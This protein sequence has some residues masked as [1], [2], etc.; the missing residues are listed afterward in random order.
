MDIAQSITV[1]MPELT[2]AVLSMGLLLGGL[3]K[4]ADTFR[5]INLLALIALALTGMAIYWPARLELLTSGAQAAQTAFMDMFRED[6]FA[7]FAK[8]LILLASALAL[9]MSGKPLKN[10]R[11][12]RPEYYALV[13]LATLGMMLMV[14]ANHGLALYVGLELQSLTLYVLA[15]FRRDDAQSSEAGLKY[16][17]L[18][19]LSSGLL[20]YGLSL[21]YGFAGTLDFSQL[22]TSLGAKPATQSQGLVVG[23]VFICAALAFKI[24]AV[25]FHMWTPDVY[26]GAP[27]PVTTLLAAAPKIA[28]MALLTRLLYGPFGAMSGQWQQILIFAA[29]ASMLVGASAGVIQSSLK[30]LMAYS[31]IANIGFA[32]IGLATAGREGAEASFVYLSIYAVNALGAFGVLLALR[33]DGKAL[34]DLKDVAGLARTNPALAF[35]MAVFMFSLAGVPPLA[36]F[37][38]KYV[39]FV[40]AV[41]AHMVPL[42]VLGVVASAIA[43]FYYLRIVKLMYFDEAQGVSRSAAAAD[44]V[45]NSS[46]QDLGLRAVIG[47]TAL[48]ALAF[49]LRP[50]LLIEGAHVAIGSLLRG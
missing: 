11:I 16:F 45:A 9:A 15:S 50:S 37:F 10:E 21:I 33:G 4:R 36:G 30:R 17:V 32:L 18:G 2:L 44:P 27:T 19:A 26:E 47:A 22:A 25:P 24:S 39:V 14:S 3:S 28:A 1:V 12:A 38:G 20:L 5:G 8:T 46:A 49:V 40:A 43:A 23:V 31:T 34:D 29:A 41:K 7:R 13:L 35:A 42:A 48:A 6:A